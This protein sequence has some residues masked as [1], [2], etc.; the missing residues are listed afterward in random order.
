MSCRHPP[1]LGPAHGS[2]SSTVFAGSADTIPGTRSRAG[3]RVRSSKMEPLSEALRLQRRQ[4]ELEE[5]C[6]GPAESG[7]P[8]SESYISEGQPSEVPRRCPRDPACVEAPAPT[9]RHVVVSG[10]RGRAVVDFALPRTLTGE[11]PSANWPSRSWTPASGIDNWARTT[12]PG[13]RVMR[14]GAPWHQ[15][16]KPLCGTA[17]ASFENCVVS[18]SGIT[19]ETRT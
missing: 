17:L 12:A 15:K 14:P 10:H 1:V 18:P 9:G 13:A 2:Q 3:R 8:K 7:S 5:R 19:A 16:P 11:Q 6:A 4:S